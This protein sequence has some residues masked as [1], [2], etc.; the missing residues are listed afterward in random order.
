VADTGAPWNI[1]YAEPTNLVRDWPALSEDVAEAVAGG[2]TAVVTA[3]IGSNAVTATFTSSFATSSTSFQN[4][5]LEVTITP[6]SATSRILIAANGVTSNNASNDQQS[7]A[8]L[9]RDTTIIAEFGGMSSGS[10]RETS[11]PGVSFIDS[12]GTTS[13]VT[14]R[15][16]FRSGTGVT[17]YWGRTNLDS[18]VIDSHMTAIEVAP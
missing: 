10:T 7:I 15:V 12:P 13:P 18:R 1:P 2:L 6:S 9:A 17:S 11:A 4:T 8:A 14:Y 16:R 5:G 3:G